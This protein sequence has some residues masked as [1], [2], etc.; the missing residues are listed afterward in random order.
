M[1]VFASVFLL[2]GIV[3]FLLFIAAGQPTLIPLLFGVSIFGA[4]LSQLSSRGSSPPG[5]MRG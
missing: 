3:I 1:T 5:I 2:V 4:L